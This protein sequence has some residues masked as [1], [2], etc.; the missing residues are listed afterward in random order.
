[1]YEGAVGTSIVYTADSD[2]GEGPGQ[3]A[4]Q[5]GARQRQQ[6]PEATGY[7]KASIW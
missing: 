3:R 4:A 1:M 5:A 6:T 2:G 7:L